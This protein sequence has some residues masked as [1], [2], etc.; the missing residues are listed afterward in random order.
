MSARTLGRQAIVRNTWIRLSLAIGAFLV[1][2]VGCVW[3]PSTELRRY[4]EAL[5]LSIMAP[6][7]FGAGEAVEFSLSLS[8]RSAQLVEACLGPSRSVSLKSGSRSTTTSTSV[9]HPGCAKQFR[10][11]PSGEFV[12]A[13]TLETPAVPPGSGK[14]E[15]AVEIVDPQHCG[16]FGCAS[17]EVRASKPVTIR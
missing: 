2:A 8:N 12:W 3:L 7:L 4:E 15:L 1:P 16:A 17:T 14:I 13:E 9:D 5:A 11:E 10:L 6:D